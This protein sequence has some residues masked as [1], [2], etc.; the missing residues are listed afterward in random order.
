MKKLIV[1]TMVGLL[2]LAAPAFASDADLEARVEALEEKVLELENRL[3]E[4]DGQPMETETSS[5]VSEDMVSQEIDTQAGEEGPL[6]F[7]NDACRITITDI[8]ETDLDGV[9][10]YYEQLM[11]WVCGE[12]EGTYVVVLFELENLTQDSIAGDT[13]NDETNINGWMIPGYMG[14]VDVSAG[15]KVRG[16]VN[17]RLANC[18]AD[19]IDDVQSISVKKEL[20][21][22]SY[23]YLGDFYFSITRA[24]DG[25]IAK[26]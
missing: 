13:I 5:S 11:P 24:G 22:S 26:Q 15:S 9:D 19:S 6:V 12:E 1:S 17:I 10:N 7:E 20:R 3:A 23:E 25:W 4:L 18:D 16:F 14:M 2:L 21:N 8:V